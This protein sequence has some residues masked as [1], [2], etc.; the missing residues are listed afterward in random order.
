MNVWALYEVD[1][2]GYPLVSLH[3]TVEGA[4]R[5]ALKDSESYLREGRGLLWMPEKSGGY[6][7]TSEGMGMLYTLQREEVEE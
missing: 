3:Q 2:D 4:Q 6:Y 1:A 7:A 5:R